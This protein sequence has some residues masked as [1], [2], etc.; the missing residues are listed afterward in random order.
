MILSL[1]ELTL[2]NFDGLIRTTDLNGAVLQIHQHN[3][4]AEHAPVSMSMLTEAIFTF[5]LLRLFAAD[6]AIRKHYYFEESKITML[7]PGSVPDRQR[8][9]TPDNSIPRAILPTISIFVCGVSAARHKSSASVTKHL[10]PNQF[11]VL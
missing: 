7:E 6:N 1:T 10:T 8:T 11:R 4:P 9:T 3:F 2:V 5:D